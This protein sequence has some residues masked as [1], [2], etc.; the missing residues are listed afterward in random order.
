MLGIKD[1]DAKAQKRSDVNLNN[2]IDSTDPLNILKKS[3]EMLKTLPVT[4]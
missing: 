2:K 3:L 1:L 4:K